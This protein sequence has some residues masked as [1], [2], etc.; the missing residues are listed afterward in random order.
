LIPVTVLVTWLVV[1]A[2]AVG[3]IY[4]LL[5]AHSQR[6]AVLTM[7]RTIGIGYPALG[8]AFVV[9]LALLNKRFQ[10]RKSQ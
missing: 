5:M 7:L 9:L 8:I 3:V 4:V 10:N 2:I 1:T 6:D